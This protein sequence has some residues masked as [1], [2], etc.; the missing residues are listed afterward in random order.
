MPLFKVKAVKLCISIY[1]GFYV[2]EGIN[3]CMWICEG[4]FSFGYELR[5]GVNFS[6]AGMMFQSA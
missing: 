4:F 1:I 3:F 6:D 2:W 5:R